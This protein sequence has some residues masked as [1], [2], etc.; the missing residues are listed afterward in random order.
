MKVV[1]LAGGL[2][3]RISE[4]S[5]LRPKPLIE[6]G[7]KP[8]LWH[9]MKI[10]S[11]HGINEFIICCGY[12][13]YMI[14]DYF[15]NYYLYMSDVTFDIQNNQMNVHRNQVEQWKVTLID[16]GLETMTGGRLKRVREY[17]KGE[18]FCL[19]YG[20]GVSNVDIT[21]LLKFHKD[22]KKLATLTAVQPAG[23]FGALTIKDNIVEQFH[24]KPDGDGGWINAGF[25]VL[26]PGIFDLIE[27]D[28]TIW[29]E[30]PME[31]LAKNSQLRA[32]KH[33]G[34][35]KSMDTLQDKNTLEA[36][37]KKNKALWKTWD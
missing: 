31:S 28:E 13:G 24:E 33:R 8:I 19:T 14:K 15:A 2:G 1:I 35:W 37:W 29:E 11:S 30:S 16:T 27:G 4:E 18:T 22:H 26:E 6:I 9:I 20:D 3:T 7:N 25:F 23:R 36:L 5:Y 17:I 21:E 32:Y 10:Y 12:R 34:F